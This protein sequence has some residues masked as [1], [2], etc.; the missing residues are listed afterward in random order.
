MCRKGKSPSSTGIYSVNQNK[1][2]A[3]GIT[4][5]LLIVVLL[6]GYLGHVGAKPARVTVT[7]NPPIKNC[8]KWGTVRGSL[9]C[10]QC[11]AKYHLAAGKCIADCDMS[12][13]VAGCKKCVK[14]RQVTVCTACGTGYVFKRGGQ[15]GVGGLCGE[16]SICLTCRPTGAI[17]FHSSEDAMHVSWHIACIAVP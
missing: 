13:R 3:R 10:A 6:C 16:S 2:T 7:V 11:V 1:P 8:R 15:R 14:E 4:M 9:E 12:T 5:M 17:V